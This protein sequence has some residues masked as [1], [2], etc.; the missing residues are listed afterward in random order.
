[1]RG[2]ARGLF[3]ISE[4]AMLALCSALCKRKMSPLILRARAGARSQG[5]GR[6]AELG[7]LDSEIRVLK[8]TV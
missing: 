7:S 3:W 8:A 4:V 5:E 2:A 1:M 6:A